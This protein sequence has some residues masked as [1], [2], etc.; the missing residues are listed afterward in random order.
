M[1]TLNIIFRKSHTFCPRLWDEIYINEKGEVFSCCHSKPLALGCINDERLA[2][3]IN[4]EIIQGLRQESLDG[5]LGCYAG[6]TLLDKPEIVPEKR[7]LTIAYSDLR[8]LKVM[9]GEG[10]NIG[11]VMC[12]QAHKNRQQVDYERLVASVDLAPFESI[13]LQGGEP[14][15]LESARRFFDHAAAQGKKVSFLTNGILVSEQW[16]EKIAFNSDF[17]YFSLNAATKQTHERINKGSRWETVLRNVQRVRDAREKHQTDV[18]IM[19]HMTI[20]PENLQE[21]P[22]FIAGL[23]DFGFDSVD[24]GYDWTVPRYLRL[25]ISPIK[26][27]KLKRQISEAIDKVDD[28]SRVYLNRLR[29]LHLA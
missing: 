17:V 26:R 10:C 15:F 5:R 13:E 4:K 14:L 24:F 29:Q 8:R 9:F 3:I 1:S 19:G 25:G 2:D 12:S 28:P 22:L 11:C 16:A 18:R 27:W 21:I 20:V 23:R 6:C 7:P